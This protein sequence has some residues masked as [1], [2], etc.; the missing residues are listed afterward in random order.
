MAIAKVESPTYTPEEHDGDDDGEED[1]PPL[2]HRK[3]RRRRED[4][5]MTVL[6]FQVSDRLV[7]IAVDGG[8]LT[9]SEIETL[10]AYLA[11]QEKIAP[12]APEETVDHNFSIGT[13]AAH[14][15]DSN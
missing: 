15:S 9:R 7:E 12:A 4:G 2:D 3:K 14:R 5:S 8:P 6:S 11:I 13:G 1:N 10:K